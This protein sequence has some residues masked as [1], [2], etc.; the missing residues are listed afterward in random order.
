MQLPLVSIAM[1][2]YNGAKFMAKQLES[3][4]NQTYKNLEIVIV[5]DRSTDDTVAIVEQFAKNDERIKFYQNET[6]LGFNK[7]FE[8]AVNLT[9]GDYISISD[10]DDIWLPTKIEDLLNAIAIIGSS[11]QTRYT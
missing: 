4:I 9:T 7:N 3:I 11:S 1:C 8:K 2:T 5:D 10:Q 6:N